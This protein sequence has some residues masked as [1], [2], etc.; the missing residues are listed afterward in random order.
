MTRIESAVINRYAPQITI[1]A[2]IGAISNKNRHLINYIRTIR[3]ES[4]ALFV[5]VSILSKRC[6]HNK[7]NW[8]DCCWDVDDNECGGGQF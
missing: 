4:V 3:Q 1:P 6:K 7:N 5:R 2:S 8:S